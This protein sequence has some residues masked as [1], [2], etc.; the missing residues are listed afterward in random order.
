MKATILIVDDDNINLKVMGKVLG[1]EGYATILSDNATEALGLLEEYPADLIIL[2]V[3]MPGMD[4]IQLCRQIKSKPATEDIPVIFLSGISEIDTM[5]EGFN[6]GAIDYILK[7]FNLKLF[8]TKVKTHLEL[9]FQREELRVLNQHLEQKV[10]E[11]TMKLEKALAE[12]NK[13]DQMKSEFLTI[14]SHEIRTPLNGILCVSQLIQAKMKDE[15]LNELFMVLESSVKRLERFS[16]NALLITN[17]KSG[18]YQL[19]MQDVS[20]HEIAGLALAGLQPEI[21][22]KKIHI[23]RQMNTAETVWADREL[24]LVAFQGILG[25]AVKYTPEGSSVSLRISSAQNHLAVEVQDEGEGFSIKA[26]Q[27][28]YQ[29]FVPGEPFVNEN[30][31]IDLAL[32][33]LIMDIHGG[34]LHVMNKNVGASVSMMFR[35]PVNQYSQVHG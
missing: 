4:G 32:C 25:N 11:R 18:R 14:I 12:L 21:R 22:E 31:G 17:L 10:V 16:L 23:H 27:H 30:E 28:L 24:L 35:N 29:F 33:K 13:L 15:S 9:R 3:M 6:Y 8:L 7:P 34:D 1:N 20:L 26:L 2:D 19:K 5:V